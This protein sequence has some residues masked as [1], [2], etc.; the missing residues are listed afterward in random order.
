MAKTMVID[1]IVQGKPQG[2]GRH[3]SA[4]TS[5]GKL[6]TY[7]PQKTVRYEKDIAQA[8][9][10]EAG[11]RRLVWPLDRVYHL[12]VI[13]YFPV[14]KSWTKARKQR[15]YN[16]EL[17]PTVVPDGDNILKAVAD[18]LNGLA[19]QD[20]R[21]VTFQEVKKMYVKE[22]MVPCIHVYITTIDAAPEEPE[23]RR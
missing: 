22:Y 5:S 18:G 20:D 15:A 21:Q 23:Q 2:K 14:P 3:R 11:S 10:I 1:F 13:A 19:W 7:T 16:R 12:R 6:R 4:V 8:F 17:H 9:R